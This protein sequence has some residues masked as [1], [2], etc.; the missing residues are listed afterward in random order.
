MLFLTRW[1]GVTG[2]EAERDRAG[3]P[4]LCK[5]I[6]DKVLLLQANAA[7]QQKRALARGTH[8]KGI[9]V[10]GEFE[11][12]DV[13]ANRD[14]L[15][16]KR[17]ARG[18]FAKAAVYPAVV[19][20]ANAD[21]NKNSD[22]KPDVRALSF[23][24]DL[25]CAGTVATDAP[26]GRQDFSLQNTTTLPIN[27]ARA[28]LATMKVI[29]AANPAAALWS[30]SF[31]DELRVVRTLVLAQLQM[32]QTVRPYQQ[33]TYGSNVPFRHG[34]TDVV[35]FSLLPSPANPANP[36]Q[37]SNPDAL[38]DE[39]ARHVDQDNRL[40]VFDFRVQ[41]LDVDRM[42]YWGK[43]RDA[44]F[45]IEN[46]SI[47]WNEAQAPFHTMGRL[48]LLGKSQLDAAASE[49]EYIDVTGNSTPDSLP[50]GS[51]NRAR[52]HGEVASRRARAR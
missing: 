6:V 9:C 51:I 49:A 10:R 3:E 40:S 43:R 47:E 46:A 29:T 23:S 15:L 30:L 41:F 26:S 28:F 24:V 27:D 14:P 22:F 13:A 45:W 42:T 32:M 8:A 21:Q 34:P 17:L 44:D 35:K 4:A 25:T 5:E 19:R 36:L 38:K 18:M 48:S 33:L 16:A 1:F 31:S 50:V 39:L 37:R 20:F 12:F 2:S 7:T 11:V 52:S